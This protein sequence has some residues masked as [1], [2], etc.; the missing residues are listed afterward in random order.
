MGKIKGAVSYSSY[1]N[2][3]S[4]IDILDIIVVAVII[5]TAIPPSTLLGSRCF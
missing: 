5:V 1:R 4:I 2:G 3:S